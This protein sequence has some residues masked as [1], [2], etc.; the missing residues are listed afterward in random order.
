MFVL[1]SFYFFTNSWMLL[2]DSA[3][4]V[5]PMDHVQYFARSPLTMRSIQRSLPNL[6]CNAMDARLWALRL[7]YCRRMVME[8]YS[9]AEK[10]FPILMWRC[11]CGKQ[12]LEALLARLDV[13]FCSMLS[14]YSGNY[15][16]YCILFL[17]IKKSLAYSWCNYAC[18]LT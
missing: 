8:C 17:T 2:W 10:Q 5:K 1:F 7:S 12:L 3:I 6:Q 4:F 15:N 9:A 13:Y 14:I 18:W 11:S 16:Y